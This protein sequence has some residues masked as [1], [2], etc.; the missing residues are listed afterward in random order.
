MSILIRGMKMPKNCGDCFVY[1]DL[2]EYSNHGASGPTGCRINRK[3][4]LDSYYGNVGRPHDCPIQADG[5]GL[6][7]YTKIVVETDEKNP[8]HIATVTAD[9]TDIEAGYRVRITPRYD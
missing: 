3:K 5:E 1:G 7:R 4:Y 6:D 9:E 8:V 2:C